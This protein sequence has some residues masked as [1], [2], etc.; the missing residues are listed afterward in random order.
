MPFLTKAWGWITNN[1]VA[2]IL[3]A[4]FF[5]LIGWEVVKRN[6]QETGRIKE[7]ERIAAAQAEADKLRAGLAK[8]ASVVGVA[9]K[10][11]GIKTLTEPYYGKDRGADSAAREAFQTAKKQLQ[12]LLSP[13]HR[14]PRTS[15]VSTWFVATYPRRPIERDAP[16]H[17]VLQEQPPPV[18]ASR[19]YRASAGST[20]DHRLHA[21]QRGLAACPYPTTP[22]PGCNSALP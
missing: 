3:I 14:Q 8:A 21:P 16:R 15:A 5:A 22:G 17:A 7:R 11:P 19:R 13:L 9:E 20:C 1:P 2:Q 6:I 4:V 10:T 12:D 18:L